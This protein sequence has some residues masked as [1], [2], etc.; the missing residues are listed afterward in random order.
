MYKISSKIIKYPEGNRHNFWKAL[1]LSFGRQKIIMMILKE[2]SVELGC[3]N[4]FPV[5]DRYDG[6][7][8]SRLSSQKLSW[9]ISLSY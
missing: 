3:K 6:K 4:L 9:N 2:W 5:S 7:I 8:Y 1:S